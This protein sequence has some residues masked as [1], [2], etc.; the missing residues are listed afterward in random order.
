MIVLSLV[1]MSVQAQ[2][3]TFVSE[4]VEAGVKAHLGLSSTDDVLQ[5]QTDTITIIDLSGLEIVDISDITFFPNLIRINLTGNKI[6]DISPLASLEHL[7]YA[8]L[9]RNALES[10]NPLI[11]A[12]S[13]SLHINVADN[14]I[15]DFSYLFSATS[16]QLLIE[17]MGV[18]Q[19]VK[20]PPYF[21]IYQFYTFINET[22][23]QEICY[24]GF[25]NMKN[26][27]TLACG[28]LTFPA[29]IDGYTNDV[30]LPEV[31]NKTT[32]VT[33][34][35]GELSEETYVVPIADYQ[36]KAGQTV[37]LSTGLPDDYF[38]SYAH[39]NSGKVET[40]GNILQYT[41]PADAAPD[42]ISFCYYK[43]YSLKGYSRFYVNWNKKGD[44]NGDG[45]LTMAD[46]EAIADH[47]IG[48]TPS[49][50]NM[51]M[52]DLNGDDKVNASDIVLLVKMIPK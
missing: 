35:N 28:S 5:S 43:G 32:K 15:Q 31:L 30:T 38:F 29:I 39:A 12:C 9:R 25:T 52:A 40:A 20:D 48:R 36:V 16:C 14:Y 26:D 3:V 37:T 44:V 17:G 49:I 24:R 21:N 19:Q 10:I 33:I 47:I 1:S 22:R 2:K 27:I 7:Q 13:D 45:K 11:F 6:E 18:Q 8:N 4:G 41:A 34:S 23:S 51:K 50:F 46:V 42:I